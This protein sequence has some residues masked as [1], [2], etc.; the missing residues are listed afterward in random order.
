MIH[1]MSA[2]G[3]L[4]ALWAGELAVTARAMQHRLEIR[5]RVLGC[6]AGRTLQL[7]DA[8]THVDIA[9]TEMREFRRQIAAAEGAGEAQASSNYRT[10]LAQ[11]AKEI[12]SSW[13]SARVHPPHSC[14][15]TR[16][17]WERW[18]DPPSDALGPLP[19]ELSPQN[20]EIC[21][22]EGPTMRCGLIS[23]QGGAEWR[24]D[25]L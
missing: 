2:F 7:R 17:Q 23:L 13:E 8:L 14:T 21:M 22:S 10:L 15:K 6:V 3:I 9:A 4:L 24:E 12:A 20:R 25:P 16:E 19:P 11:V 5:M 1:L 18:Q